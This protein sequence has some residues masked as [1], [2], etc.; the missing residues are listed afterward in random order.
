MESVAFKNNIVPASSHHPYLL[1]RDVCSL[2]EKAVQNPLVTL[3]AGAG[4]GKTQAVY[5]FLQE[6]HAVKTW[7]QLSASDNMAETFWDKFI[8][9]VSIHSKA[10]AS[11]LLPIGFPES[12]RQFEQFL[13]VLDKEIP[14]NKK[15]IFVFDDFHWICDE[16]VLQFAEKLSS[17]HLPH[18][19][20]ILISRTEPEINTISLLAKGL[21]FQINEAD[22]RFRQDEMLEYFKMLG[23]K[24]APQA[25][26]DMYAVTD[27]WAF[28]IH[29][30]GLSLKNGTLQENR[31]LA[32]MKMNIFKLIEAEI[33]SVSSKN[34]QKF[35]IGLSLID[36]WS[37]NLL[38]EL[39][40]RESLIDEM[41]KISSLVQ[42]DAYTNVYRIHH[43]FSEYLSQ[44]QDL[45]S[46]EE[47]R[48]IYYKAAQWCAR[49]G[50]QME[51]ILYYEKAG[52]YKG[53]AEV[54]Y[55]MAR[56]T[57][58]RVAEFLLGVLGRIPEQAF[59]E[60]VELYI[61]Q[62][63]MLQTLTRFEEAYAQVHET[64]EEFESL[65]AT[66][67]NC[68]VLSECYLNLGFIG[69]YTA[70]HTNVRDY[71]DYFEKG[72]RYFLRSGHMVKG[73]K[74]RALVSA[75][76][77]RIG[78]PAAK[79][80]LE[81]GNAIFARYVNY[82]IEAKAGIMNGMAELANCEVA[83]FKANYKKAEGLAYQAIRK[84]KDTEQFQIEN[85]ALFFLLRINIHKG[86]PERLRDI[87][88]QLNAQLE[89]EEFLHSYTLYDIVVGWFYAQIRQTDRIAVWLRNS[90][91]KSDLNP[92]LF[93]LENL[94]RAKSYFAE[95]K[96]HA[97]LNALEGQAGQY[98]LEA[99]LL[100][101]L[102]LT[103]LRA[104][105][106]Y[107]IGEKK[108]AIR[109][110]QE[111]Y[112][113]SLADELDMPF[114]ELGKDMRT[115]T[116]AAMK[117]KNCG[118][119][120]SWL[121]KIHKKSST[122]AKSL[123]YIISEYRIFHHI[124][125]DIYTLTSREKEILADLCRGLS[126]TEIACNRNISLSTVKTLIQSIYSKLGTQNIAETIWIAATFKLIE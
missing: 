41:R 55:T 4:Y 76:V 80:D 117:E 7:L 83:Y 38:A 86:N 78:S 67:T 30:L 110:L 97:A 50:Y 106:K 21:V 5:S 63:K 64:I 107:H 101:K 74:E 109:I 43:L 99:F 103:V 1:R 116:V 60:S 61:I 58:S 22:L 34:L 73:P 36:H 46:G 114:I 3:V 104:V 29:L 77:T 90:F 59:H 70:L 68:W 31:A 119:P 108:E 23:I 82:A 16:L 111:A 54:A 45:L 44:K 98:G 37:P 113:V 118:I 56:M 14:T 92:L 93:G 100:G 28:S 35:L 121:E 6:Y 94:V 24:L 88:Q 120:Q 66:P 84:A 91:N 25:A 10:L 11:K 9:A 85:R 105:C 71:S 123:S 47:K 89:Q 115:L 12:E 102:E 53:I 18:I 27:G 2:L 13:A 52:D 125:T 15:H 17:L 65:P 95:R 8:K 122:Y 79:G 20:V 87:F 32:A 124:N 33:F 75:Y 69:L 57:P 112:T 40:Q 96:Y 19:C 48:A 62:N 72:H 126:R 42:Y 26:T 49:N 39:S 81:R 51:A